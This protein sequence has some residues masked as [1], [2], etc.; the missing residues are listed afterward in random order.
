MA[1]VAQ[2]QQLDMKI[3]LTRSLGPISW[4]WATSDGS[5]RKKKQGGTFNFPGETVSTYKTT[6]I[7]D[8]MSIV[9]K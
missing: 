4:S 1:V 8:A 7:I 2:T 3:F 9:Q 5:L 6:C